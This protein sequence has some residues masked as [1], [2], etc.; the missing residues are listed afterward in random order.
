VRRAKI[1][2]VRVAASNGKV[3][4]GER[5]K[6]PAGAATIKLSGRQRP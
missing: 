1:A 2:K 5:R 3:N 4:V 6:R